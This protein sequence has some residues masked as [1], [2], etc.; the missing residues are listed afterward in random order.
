MSMQSWQIPPSTWNMKDPVL[1]EFALSWQWF[2]ENRI[3]RTIVVQGLGLDQ[4]E[5][6]SQGPN[7]SQI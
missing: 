6:T 5:N 4:Q 1:A 2:N 7:F 3:V